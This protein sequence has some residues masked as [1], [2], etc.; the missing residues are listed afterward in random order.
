MR[1]FTGLVAVTLCLGFTTTALGEEAAAP[2]PVV[3]VIAYNAGTE[4]T[5]FLVPFG[6]LTDSGLA[7]VHAVALA[8]GPVTFRPAP[9]LAELPGTVAAFDVAY[10]RGADYVIVPAVVDPDSAALISWLRAQHSKG[11]VIMSI[12][13]GAKVLAQAGLLQDRTATA[14]WYSLPELRRQFPATT[15]RDDR[16]Y[17]FDENVVT[18]SGISASVPATFA[19]LER[20]AGAEA[21][22]R[23]ASSLGITT[24]PAAHDGAAFRKAHE[25]WNAAVVGA[26]PPAMMTEGVGLSLPAQFDEARA[27]LVM[28]AYSRTHRSNVVLHSGDASEIRSRHGLVFK[29]SRDERV[30]EIDTV[31]LQKELAETIDATL[32][33]IERDYGVMAADH[34]AH[35]LEYV[36]SR[37]S[38]AARQ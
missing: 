9:G 17:V 15:W 24:W 32:N 35:Q 7:D 20:I 16:R 18:T 13:D 23:F 8:E 38:A 21:T 6:V 4:V 33:Q 1:Y 28:D 19:L 34:V 31:L 10:P 37:A 25:A 2:R 26:R 29:T 5:D 30:H 27:A 22:A 11:A 3:A 14:H 12:C 36:R